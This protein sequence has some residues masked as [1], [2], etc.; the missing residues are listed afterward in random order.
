M[1]TLKLE[2]SWR[3]HYARSLLDLSPYICRWTDGLSNF[4]L[5]NGFSGH[6]IM[7]APA[8]GRAVT[9]LLSEGVFKSIDLSCFDFDRVKS[10]QAFSELGIV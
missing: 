10:E 4:L 7:H 3:G 6:G 2:R 8:T 1:Q 5:A 9:E